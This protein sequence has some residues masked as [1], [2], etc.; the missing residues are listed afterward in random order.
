MESLPPSP[1][2][3]SPTRAVSPRA[4]GMLLDW[5][6]EQIAN[7]PVQERTV[8]RAAF[9]TLRALQSAPVPLARLQARVTLPARAPP[10]QNCSRKG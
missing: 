3:P 5:L 2:T 8:H 4:V 6:G 1:E 9:L 10:N 7:L